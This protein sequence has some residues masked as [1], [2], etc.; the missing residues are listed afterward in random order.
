MNLLSTMLSPDIHLIL[1]FIYIYEYYDANLVKKSKNEC[2]K[3]VEK[4]ESHVYKGER[5]IMILS[6]TSCHLHV[7]KLF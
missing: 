2:R 3:R 1:N 5:R 7:V 4:R 6:Y